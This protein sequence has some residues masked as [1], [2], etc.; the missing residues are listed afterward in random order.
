M[1]QEW[2]QDITGLRAVAV[3]L[4]LGYHLQHILYPESGVLSGGWIGVDIFFVISGFLMTSIIW[5]DM[6]HGSF[7]LFEFYKHRAQRIC[8]A[9]LI[10]VSISLGIGLLTFGSE[11]LVRLALSGYWALVMGSNFFFSF[12][13]DYFNASALDQPLLHTWSL[14]AEWQFYL[15]YPFF[16]MLVRR[17]HLA[18]LS[19]EGIQSE[20][21]LANTPKT[22]PSNQQA[23]PEL[24]TCSSRTH[25]NH[26]NHSNFLNTCTHSTSC[27]FGSPCEFYEHSTISDNSNFS[28][29]CNHCEHY[30]HYNLQHNVLMRR[31]LLCA[32]VFCLGSSVVLSNFYPIHSYYLLPSRC[33]EMLCGSLAW[34]YPLNYSKLKWLK[35]WLVELIGL[36]L[37]IISACGLV[38]AQGWPNFMV[39]F[40]MLGAYLCLAAHNRQTLLRWSWLQKIGLCSYALYLVHWPILVICSK[41]GLTWQWHLDE[42]ALDAVALGASADSYVDFYKGL[43]GLVLLVGAIFGLSWLLHI[44]VERRRD[45]GAKTCIAYLIAALLCFY[46]SY[47][48]VPWRLSYTPSTYAQYGGHGI[49]MEGQVHEIGDLNRPTDLILVGDSFARHYTLD[50][51][52]RQLHTTT[53]LAD[54]CYSFAHHVNQPND[55]GADLKCQRRYFELL[56]ALEQNPH[57]PVLVAQDWPRYALAL[58]TRKNADYAVHDT[59]GDKHSSLNYRGQY[60]ITAV[61]NN[62][63]ALHST[64]TFKNTEHFKSTVS[65]DL[66]KMSGSKMTDVKSKV[67]NSVGQ[68]ES[69]EFQESY[70]EEQPIFVSCNNDAKDTQDAKSSQDINAYSAMVWQ[71]LQQLAKDAGD[72]KVFVL[73]TPLQPVYDIGSTC[74]YLHLLNNPV[75]EVLRQH[76]TC[77]SRHK[78][79][80][81]PFNQSLQSMVQQFPNFEYL[82]PNAALC[83]EQECDLLIDGI[84]PI[85]QDGLHYSWAGSVK[86]MSYL[87]LK[88]G[89]PQGRLRLRFEDVRSLDR[90]APNII[91]YSTPKSEVDYPAASKSEVNYPCTEDEPNCRRDKVGVQS[92]DNIPD[93]AIS[94]IHTPFLEW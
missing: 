54:G 7:N 36:L 12:H 77:V 17:W 92:N 4:V 41:L 61:S 37:I 24:N 89:L 86:V 91:L 59:E 53:I 66:G 51:Q 22:L 49:A 50:L 82:D 25:H 68:I 27:N 74:M 9:L 87:L 3:I 35:P 88:M 48:S 16:L 85:Y 75:S 81:I 94:P 76:V 57:V 45:F 18:I 13:T 29:H 93:F 31:M 46:V 67:N 56:K 64:D 63:N 72:R 70:A 6:E 2:R 58:V 69:H 39:I 20:Q 38:S 21:Y 84:L 33:G 65:S 28:E 15:L 30:E 14:G 44:A 62:A 26:C 43:A 10:V 42:V 8:P 40:P 52:E 1:V 23:N 32:V 55:G 79:R 73:G 47:T 83:V 11:D 80:L 5:R 71:D 19:R 90:A 60:K 78:L 34:A